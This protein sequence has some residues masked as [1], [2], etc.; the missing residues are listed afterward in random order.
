MFERDK[1]ELRDLGIP[2][3]TG[4]VSQTDPTEGYRINREAYALPAVGADRRRGGRGGGGDAAVGVARAHHRDPGRAAE[5]ARRRHRHRSRGRRRDDHLDRRAAR[6]PRVGEG[7]RNPVVRHRFRAGRA[8]SAPPV[9]Q[10][11]VH[12]PH[13]RALGCGHRP[14]PLVSGRPRPRPRR[15][16]HLPVVAD[17][18]RGDTDRASPAWSAGPRHRTCA[19]S[20]TGWSATG[21]RRRGEDLGRRGPRDGVAPAG[22]GR[23][24]ADAG[25]RAGE[26]IAR[27]RHVR[28]GGAGGRQLRRRRGG[29]GAG[30]TARRSSI[31]RLESAGAGAA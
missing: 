7:A 6:T 19:R 2:L 23:R 26:E 25:G 9:A 17:R 15:R 5:V 8:V 12:H 30:V 20:S 29:T 14:R 13:R 22:H 16:S 1:N 28:P 18:R 21:P 31:A 4:R 3:E 10:R 24:T 27:H 11:A